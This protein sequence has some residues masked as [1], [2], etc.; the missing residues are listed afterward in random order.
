M[1][2]GGDT[3]VLFFLDGIGVPHAGLFS[4]VIKIGKTAQISGHPFPWLGRLFSKAGA[5]LD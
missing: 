4:V 1:F 5:L 3:N 2:N